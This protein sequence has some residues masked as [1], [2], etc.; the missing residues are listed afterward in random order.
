MPFPG[1]FQGP[2]CTVNLLNDYSRLSVATPLP[3]MT[4]SARRISALL[5][6]C[7]ETSLVHATLYTDKFTSVLSIN[8]RTSCSWLKKAEL[9]SEQVTVAISTLDDH[10]TAFKPHYGILKL[11]NCEQGVIYSASPALVPSISDHIISLKT[12][13]TI[14]SLK[15][16][17]LNR[18]FT[19]DLQQCYHTA[20]C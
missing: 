11:H 18:R 17:Q 1:I 20:E 13:R 5:H 10:R 8:H 4:P 2:E 9:K 14:G 15:W 19:W 7:R 12:H 3:H 6:M 16:N